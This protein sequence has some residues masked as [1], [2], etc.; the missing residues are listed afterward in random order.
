VS[1]F[2]ERKLGQ[3]E[4]SLVSAVIAEFEAR[5]VKMRIYVVDE[6][7]ESLVFKANIDVCIIRDLNK[8]CHSVHTDLRDGGIVVARGNVPY[9]AGNTELSALDEVVAEHLESALTVEIVAPKV[10]DI[11]PGSVAVI[12]VKTNAADDLYLFFVVKSAAEADE[13]RVKARALDRLKYCSRVSVLL[14]RMNSVFDHGFSPI[15]SF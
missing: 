1:V 3:R 6:V 8:L 12:D 2:R 7:E 10:I 15:I 13:N 5:A 4:A 9:S 11:V 14:A